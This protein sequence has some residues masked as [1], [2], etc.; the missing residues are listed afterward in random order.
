MH[1][2][3]TIA[4]GVGIAGVVVVGAMA[5]ALVLNMVLLPPAVAAAPYLANAQPPVSTDRRLML[6]Y[7][8]KDAVPPRVFQRFR[9]YAGPSVRMVFFDD[10]ECDAY[11]AR[12]A[13]GLLHKYRALGGAHGADL[14]RFLW[15]YLEGGIYLD[16]KTMCT[17]PIVDLFPQGELVVCTTTAVPNLLGVTPVHI[18]ILA[19]PRGHPVFRRMLHHIA[20][21]PPVVYT[22]NYLS[23]VVAMGKCVQDYEGAGGTV[24]RLHERCHRSCDH[25]DRYGLCCTCYDGNG[26]VAMEVRDPAYP[27]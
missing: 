24:H 6:T 5:L 3:A 4:I 1:P 13:P 19:G 22:L 7:K 27:Y 26:E 20:R 18:G 10:A 17:R 16:I 9:S 21:T 12:Y 8:R 11:V 23:N 14:F 15:L 2:A 25:K